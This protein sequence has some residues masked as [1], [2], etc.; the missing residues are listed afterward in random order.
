MDLLWLPDGCSPRWPRARGSD[1][2]R[3]A[4]RWALLVH[5]WMAAPFLLPIAANSLRSQGA[6]ASSR[7]VLEAKQSCPALALRRS[8]STRLV[9]RGTPVV[10]CWCWRPMRAVGR[11][12]RS[13][14]RSHL[15]LLQLSPLHVS[16]GCCQINYSPYLWK[17]EL[18]FFFPP[19]PPFFSQ[20]RLKF[21]PNSAPWGVPQACHM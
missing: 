13:G 20:V 3:R 10:Q 8:C 17:K 12:A 16:L 11:A 5:C 2:G 1:G 4:A 7:A 9:Q 19:P 18:L 15:F 21:R 14:S 6:F